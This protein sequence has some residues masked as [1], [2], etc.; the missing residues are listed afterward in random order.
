MPSMTKQTPSKNILIRNIAVIQQLS[1]KP[2]EIIMNENK[3]IGRGKE[4]KT[5][6][7]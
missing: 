3:V 1:R 2:C 6:I 4:K 5:Y 7:Q